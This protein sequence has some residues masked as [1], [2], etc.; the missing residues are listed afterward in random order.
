MEKSN[1]K[2][3]LVE[4]WQQKRLNYITGWDI[5]LGKVITPRS[6]KYRG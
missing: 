2:I 5:R 6:K 1:K 3:E 4:D